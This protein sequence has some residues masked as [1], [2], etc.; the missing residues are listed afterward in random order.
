M[1]SLTQNAAVYN[2]NLFLRSIYFTGDCFSNLGEFNVGFTKRLPLKDGSVPSLFGPADSTESQPVNMINNRCLY[3]LSSIQNM[4]LW[5]WVY[6]FQETRP[7]TTDWASD[8]S[9]HSIGSRKGGV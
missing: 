1:T 8:Q 6:R 9:E 7:I 3:F 4:E 5:Q 2:P